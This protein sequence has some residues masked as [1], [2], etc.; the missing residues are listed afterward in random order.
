MMLWNKGPGKLVLKNGKVVQPNA[1]FEVEEKEA[2][3]LLAYHH[4]VEFKANGDAP[5]KKAGLSPLPTGIGVQVPTERLAVL[6]DKAK[7]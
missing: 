4:I 5:E 1:T 6:K 3:A 2:K 7:K